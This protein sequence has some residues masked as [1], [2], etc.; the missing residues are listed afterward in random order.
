MS[1]EAPRRAGFLATIRATAAGLPARLEAAR[2]NHP[3]VSATFGVVE[4]DRRV[5][6]SVLAGGISFRLFF[7]LLPF[8]LI[9]AGAL[10]F[11]SAEDADET[12][13]H[14]GLT[15]AAAKTIADSV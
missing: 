4:R 5:A 15:G 11:S 8:A 6:A 10:G 7:W 3:S 1:D 2:G 12:V 13:K 14:V 9:L